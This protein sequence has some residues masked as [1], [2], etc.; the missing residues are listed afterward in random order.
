MVLF[1]RGIWIVPGLLVAMGAFAEGGTSINETRAAKADELVSINNSAGKVNITGTKKTE[2]TV[3]GTLGKNTERLDIKSVD[4]RTSIDVIIPKRARNVGGTTLEVTVPTSS[5]L[6]VV[7]TSADISVKDVKGSLSAESVSGDITLTGTPP[8]TT[9]R[10]ISGDIKLQGTDSDVK[11]QTVSGDAG[12]TLDSGAVSAT[13]VSGNLNVAAGRAQSAEL[14][15]VSGNVA[16]EGGVAPGGTLSGNSHSGDVGFT[17]PE[18][19]SARF[20]LE[21]FSGDVTA[22]KAAEGDSAGT[23]KKVS[24]ETGAA[25]ADVKAVTFSGSVRVRM[26]TR[27]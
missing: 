16:F 23:G 22:D 6:K 15:S 7:T 8:K 12:V 13:S 21:S 25:E 19:T 24:F 4:G 27:R 18:T 14:E 17:L 11:V 3:T 9:A 26:N 2:V 20:D 5:R 10:S 1:E